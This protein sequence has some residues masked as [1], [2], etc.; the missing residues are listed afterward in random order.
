LITTLVY[1]FFLTGLVFAFEYWA[2]EKIEPG[3][4][5]LPGAATFWP[6]LAF[7]LGTLLRSDFSGVVPRASFATILAYLEL[8]AGFV[9]V[10]IFVSVLFAILR[11]RYREDI[12]KVSDELDRSA[13]ALDSM[14]Q[15]EYSLS[16]VEAEATLVEGNPGLVKA[17]SLL[18]GTRVSN[19]DKVND[20]DG[21]A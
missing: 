7:S 20:S 3:S 19:P 10:I 17:I 5:H 11:E 13:A 4:F 8:F 2:L 21:D 14:I 6:F 18:R 12:D 9:I 16:L 15:Q 1:T